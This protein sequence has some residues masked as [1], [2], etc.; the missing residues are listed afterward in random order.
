MFIAL[1][2][3]DGTGKSAAGRHLAEALGI[4][5]LVTPGVAY[6]SIRKRLKMTRLAT[7]TML[8]THQIVF[9]NSGFAT[10]LVM[11]QMAKNQHKNGLN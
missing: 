1:E 10:R 7:R 6:E 4:Y 5:F 11:E 2:G 3:I 9:L 8:R